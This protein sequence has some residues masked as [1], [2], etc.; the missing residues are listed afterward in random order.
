MRHLLFALLLTA[1]GMMT[2]ASC[3]GDDI[4][5]LPLCIQEQLAIFETEACPST[6]GSLGGNLAIFTFRTETVYCFNYGSC[7][8]RAIEIRRADCELLCELGGP[9]GFTVCDGVPWD[10]NAVEESI[11]FQN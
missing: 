3:G 2:L 10:G 11:V 6:S 9:D 7:S 8:N 1:A 4:D 5:D